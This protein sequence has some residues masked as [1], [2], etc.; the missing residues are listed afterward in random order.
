M[1]GLSVTVNRNVAVVPSAPSATVG[2]SIDKLGMP[3]SS[4]IVPVPSAVE[5]VALVGELKVT[6]IVSL[7]SS[8]VSPVTETSMFPLVSPGANVSVPGA[9]AV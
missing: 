1:A 5:I 9:S 4:V 3:S 2:E 8:V 6:T 7:D